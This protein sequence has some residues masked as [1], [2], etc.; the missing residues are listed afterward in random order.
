MHFRPTK[1]VSTDKR[2]EEG[3]WKMAGESKLLV[4]KSSAVDCCR[5]GEDGTSN[6][7]AIQATHSDIVKFKRQDE[8]YDTVRTR[9]TGICQRAAE[10]RKAM[11][12]PNR[13]CM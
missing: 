1:E 8:N 9:L 11:E 3:D 7:C 4:T 6:V 12:D 5:P 10:S 2:K 13:K